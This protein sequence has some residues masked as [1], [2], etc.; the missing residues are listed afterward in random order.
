[1]KLPIL[2]EEESDEDKIKEYE[3]EVKIIKNKYQS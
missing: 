2:E 1:M 3:E